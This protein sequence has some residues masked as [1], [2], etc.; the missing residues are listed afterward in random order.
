MVH[1]FSRVP[2]ELA[3]NRARETWRDWRSAANR[4]PRWGWWGRWAKW[5][6]GLHGILEGETETRTAR[7]HG[8]ENRQGRGQVFI[9]ALFT[10]VLSPPRPCPA[11]SASCHLFPAATRPAPPPLPSA[12]NPTPLTRPSPPPSRCVTS[13]STSRLQSRLAASP[14]FLPKFGSRSSASP[15]KTTPASPPSTFPQKLQIQTRYLSSI[16]P[17]PIPTQMSV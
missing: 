7:E 14:F 15:Q 3:N 16:F 5:G 2:F 4:G 6:I 9:C 17:I 13:L 8:S 11:S 10:P 12:S 1:F